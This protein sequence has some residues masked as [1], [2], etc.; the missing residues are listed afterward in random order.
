MTDSRWEAVIGLEVHAQLAT[1]SKM[2]CSCPTTYLGAPPNTNVCE[3]CL[4][5]PG[6]LPVINRRAVELTVKTALALGCRVARH[7]RFDRKNYFYPDL[8]KGY[9]IS[10]YELPIGREG[11][12]ELNGRTVRVARVHL[13]EDTGKL[14][15]AG[16]A[17][18]TASESLVDL[19]R[20]GVPLM[21]IVS[22]PDL[23]SAEEAKDYAIALREILR[24]IGASEADMEKG[25]LRAEANVSVRPRGSTELGVKTEIKNINSF[26]FLQRA[27]EH[28]IRRQIEVLESGGVIVQETRG[29]SEAE[30]RTFSQRSKEYAQDYRYFPEPDLPPLELDLAWVE[31]LRASLPELPPARRR[32]LVEQ[33][34]LPEFDAGQLTLDATTADLF[35]ATV[36][37]GA[38]AKQAANWIIGFR[39]SLPAEDLA[40]LIR[41]VVEGT[42]NREQGLEVL[43][44]AQASGRSPAAL[45]QE[46]GLAQVSDEA[47]LAAVI[48]QVLVEN[49]K[50]VA[51][52]RAGR[53]QAIGALLGQVRRATGGRAN[54]KLAT[55][56]LRRRLEA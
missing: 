52:V 35:E 2:F 43:Q 17:L 36:A 42:I 25:Q 8:P 45:V 44:E 26:R 6:V 47:A 33:Y 10:Q 54:M 7:T 16:D 39:P 51:D 18:E 14:L 19:N 30:Q 27:V 22:E 38:P 32:R 37:A 49:P 4:G 23:T 40:E 56:M 21:E 53:Q 1:R 48:E 13:E 55:E 12:L 20:A 50:A 29:W 46:R 41:L 9:Q 24:A 5:M 28:E 11:R 34:G 15:H 3:V 31:R